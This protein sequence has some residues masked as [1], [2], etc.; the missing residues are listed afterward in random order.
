MKK[1]WKW[2]YRCWIIN[3]EETMP[4]FL[5]DEE[6]LEEA[7]DELFRAYQLFS[8]VADPDLVDCMIYRINAAEKR[9]AFLLK[10]LRQSRQDCLHGTAKASSR[11]EWC[12]N[13]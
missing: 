4:R 2:F 3:N 13:H 7:R 1:Q 5:T 6:L 10:Q 8:F 12:G 9:Y 11:G